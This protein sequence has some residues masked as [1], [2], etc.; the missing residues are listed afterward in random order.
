M[1]N[2]ILLF[3]LSTRIRKISVDLRAKQK[4]KRK[5]VMPMNPDWNR[6]E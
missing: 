3:N 1:N 4:V 5:Q 6:D 2:T